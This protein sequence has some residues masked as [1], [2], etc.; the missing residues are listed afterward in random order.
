MH[1]FES[2]FLAHERIAQ[3]MR[4]SAD[5]HRDPEGASIASR[6]AGAFSGLFSRL[7]NRI[8]AIASGVAAAIG[9]GRPAP[10]T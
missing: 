7:V 8:E 6:I 10:R 4:D 1:P 5:I 9:I 2:T 3:L